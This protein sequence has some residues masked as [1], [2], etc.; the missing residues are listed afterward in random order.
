M[1]PCPLPCFRPTEL[2]GVALNPTSPMLALDTLTLGELIGALRCTA[3]P[4]A[5][6]H[7]CM[8]PDRFDL[9]VARGSASERPYSKASSAMGTGE[10]VR[11]GVLDVEG[12]EDVPGLEAEFE[13]GMWAGRSRVAIVLLR[14]WCFVMC[15]ESSAICKSVLS[16]RRE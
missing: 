10:A 16:R 3:D 9:I 4:E 15:E 11:T 7:E 13:E 12:R 14:N 6:F 5:A 2:S 1:L 8:L